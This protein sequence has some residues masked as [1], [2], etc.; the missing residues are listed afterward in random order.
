M[1][2]L[3]L[4]NHDIAYYIISAKRDKMIGTQQRGKIESQ[5]SENCSGFNPRGF[6][7]DY[8]HHRDRD[9]RDFIILRKSFSRLYRF[10]ALFLLRLLTIACIYAVEITNGKKT[11]PYSYSSYTKYI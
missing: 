3:R 7:S 4:R 8:R 9:Y 2:F 10:G 11:P 5:K 6:S 1:D